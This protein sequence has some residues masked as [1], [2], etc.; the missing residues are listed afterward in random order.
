M[1]AQEYRELY[2]SEQIPQRKLGKMTPTNSSRSAYT[3]NAWRKTQQRNGVYVPKYWLETD[4]VDPSITYF[5][6]ELSIPKLLFGTSAIE[7]KSE[8]RDLAAQK[9]QEFCSTIGIRL[10]KQQIL[11]TIPTAVSFGKN[12]DITEVATCSQA[13]IAFSPFDDRFRSDCYI[14]KFEKG[15]SEL[16][17]NSKS[18][19]F[20]LYDK[21]REIHNNAITP[22]EHRL[23]EASKIS[24]ERDLW[25]CEILRTELT[26][27][28]TS[29]IK[30]RLKP[31][32]QG[33]PTFGNM[34]R[35]DIWADL[36]KNE[37]ERVFNHPL[38]NFVFLSTLQANVIEKLLDK[39]I[40]H[41]TTKL[42][43]RDMAEKI[44]RFGGT[45]GLK[46][47]Y[48]ET[49]K[50]RQ[51]YY[52]HLKISKKITANINLSELENLTA[53]KFHSFY[54][55]QFGIENSTQSTLF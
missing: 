53:S 13:I 15:G 44:Q 33:E 31:Y 36:L 51:T 17:F 3:S 7:P 18:S 52:N 2:F 35:D 10:F 37:V 16:Y 23:V 4:F 21:L 42:W 54:L 55:S 41:H 34:F 32:I 46:G 14:R 26:L 43:V 6:I 1:I 9:I 47:F 28:D 5:A 39:Y 50:S 25:I 40:K 19:T 11:G 48:L 30:K 8:H 24:K 45:K 49:F 22:E 29:A 20:K 27:K 38:A 12:I